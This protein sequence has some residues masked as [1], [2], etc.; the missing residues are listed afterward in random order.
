MTEQEEPKSAIEIF[1][2]GIIKQP[3]GSLSGT[4]W[5]IVGVFGFYLLVFIGMWLYYKFR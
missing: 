4:P 1:T 2:G 3:K 5:M